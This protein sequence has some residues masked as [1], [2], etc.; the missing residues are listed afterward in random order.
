MEKEINWQI[1]KG[2]PTRI[3]R[4]LGNGLMSLT[5]QIDKRWLLIGHTDNVALEYPKFQVSEAGRQR[6]IREGRKNVHAFAIGRLA[7]AE[8]IDRADL[9]QI[10]YCPYT[11][12]YFTWLGSN[13]PVTDAELLVVIDNRVFC[14]SDYLQ[15]QLTLFPNAA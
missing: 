7:F 10:Y 6:V 3:Y 8:R 12:P 1:C 13:E 5:Q 11:Q 2:L 14:T 15:P 4:N 9:K